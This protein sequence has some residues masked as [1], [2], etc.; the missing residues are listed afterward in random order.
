MFVA[1][2]VQYVMCMRRI[3]LS[4]VVSLALPYF[5]FQFFSREKFIERKMCILVYFI[6]IV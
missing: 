2:T 4:S 3:I 6:T 5:Q 1:L